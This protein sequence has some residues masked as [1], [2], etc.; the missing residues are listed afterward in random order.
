MNK[1]R[2]LYKDIFIG[3]SFVAGVFG[4]MSGEFIVSTLLFAASSLTSNLQLE[5]RFSA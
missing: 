3:V 1:S 5:S 2:N 4:F